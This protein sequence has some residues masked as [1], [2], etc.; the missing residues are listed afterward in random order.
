MST[1]SALLADLTSLTTDEKCSTLFHSKVRQLLTKTETHF[2]QSSYYFSP[3]HQNVHH[4]LEED[5]A[6]KAVL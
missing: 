1:C 2:L 5:M 4:P 3:Q 6:V